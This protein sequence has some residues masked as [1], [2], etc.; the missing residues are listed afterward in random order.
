VGQSG[1]Y[2]TTNG[3]YV[4]WTTVQALPSQTGNSGKVLTTDGTTAT[5]NTVQ[6]LPSQTGNSG[7]YLTTD[8]TTASW[9]TNP[10]TVF[11]GGAPD[12]VY[13]AGPVFDAGGVT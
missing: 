7:K 4:T 11:D 2:L 10:S 8:G 5:W 6:A 13:T 9:A 12:T 3:V 1:K